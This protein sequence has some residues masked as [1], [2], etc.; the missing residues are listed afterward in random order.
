MECKFKNPDGSCEFNRLH[1]IKKYNTVKITNDDIILDGV[2]VTNITGLTL[3]I[4]PGMKPEETLS[5]EADV[6]LELSEECSC[7]GNKI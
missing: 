3:K 1:S 5:L 4:T 7:N 2:P 6:D